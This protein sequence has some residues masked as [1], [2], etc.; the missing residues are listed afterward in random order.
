[1]YVACLDCGQELAY[2]WTSMRVGAPLSHT[3]I[4]QAASL[5]DVS[6]PEASLLRG[7]LTEVATM[8]TS[9]VRR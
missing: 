1:M 2:D 5:Q 7:A 4:A 9:F 6:K 3:G 8:A